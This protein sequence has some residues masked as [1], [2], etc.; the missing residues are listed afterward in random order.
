MSLKNYQST[1]YVNSDSP[2]YTLNIIDGSIKPFDL[3]KT[4]S[5]IGKKLPTEIIN[6][7][8]YV[9][10]NFNRMNEIIN[11]DSCKNINLLD[12]LP[13]FMYVKDKLTNE[14]TIYK[15]NKDYKLYKVYAN[16]FG[17]FIS[18]FVSNLKNTNDYSDLKYAENREKL[19]NKNDILNQINL[20][21]NIM[22]ANTIY[23]TDPLLNGGIFAKLLY[24]LRKYRNIFA[25]EQE[26]NFPIVTLSNIGN[27]SV[28]SNDY[29]K[30]FNFYGI[31]M[32]ILKYIFFSFIYILKQK[33]IAVD[34][35]YEAFLIKDI[36]YIRN[37]IGIR[38]E[39]FFD[40]I[41][42][43]NNKLFLEIVDIL[44]LNNINKAIQIISEKKLNNYDLSNFI[45]LEEIKAF[46]EYNISNAENFTYNVSDD[47]SFPMIDEDMID[48]DM[49]DEDYIFTSKN[50]PHVDVKN[51]TSSSSSIQK[52][53]F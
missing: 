28:I 9:L 50:I 29:A 27:D 22:V 8:K 3:D 38:L 2:S 30:F 14:L 52:Y 47:N 48:E 51:P 15:Y 39:K 19:V 35:K 32:I 41:F 12:Q 7:E 43:K 49:I 20:L 6:M 10:D 24:I 44:Y 13:F 40:N 33:N 21:Y 4:H 25:H 53:N 36:L 42:L 23:K 5:L 45:S 34:N 46:K 17:F 26:I 18:N 31:Y 37:T 16:G 11:D 1:K